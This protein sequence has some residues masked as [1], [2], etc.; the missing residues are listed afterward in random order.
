MYRMANLD[1]CCILWFSIFL[2]DLVSLN[3]IVENKIKD[4]N[5]EFNDEVNPH[6]VTL[7][8]EIDNQQNILTQL[9]GDY[10]KVKALSEGSDCGCKCVVR[11]LSRSACRRIHEGSAEPQD[12]YTVETVTSGSDCKCTCI[13][14]PSA[15]NPCE[16]DFRL[17]KLQDAGKDNIKLSTIMELLEGAFYGM[18]L[19]KLHSV[20]TKLINR[21][22][23]IEKA[24]SEKSQE[25]RVFVKSSTHRPA[26]GKESHKEADKKKPV[27]QAVPPLKGNTTAGSGNREG[28]YEERL[29]GNQGF[30]RPLLKR[31]QPEFHKGTKDDQEEQRSPPQSKAA[32]QDVVIRGVTYYKSD[33]GDNV[34]REDQAVV[35]EVV[36]GDGSVDLL[37]EDQ[38][39]KEGR[40]LSKVNK[41]SKKAVGRA[42]QVAR[43]TLTTQKHNITVAEMEL[44]T[45][46]PATAKQIIKQMTKTMDPVMVTTPS[47][48]TT[49]ASTI[50]S[51]TAARITSAILNT[52][53]RIDV[54]NISSPSNTSGQAEKPK[55]RI[56]W[57]ES[58][59]DQKMAA[60]S[61]KNPGICKDTLATIGDPVTHNTFGHSEG[62]WMKDP[63]G[64]DG[65]IYVTNYYHGNNLLEFSNIEAF[66]E[67]RPTNSYKLPYNWMGTGHVVYRKAFYYNRAF[68]R[69]IIKFDLNR[70]YV[71]AWTVLDDAVVDEDNH[72]TGRSDIDFAVDESGLWVIYPAMDD[73][74]FHQE[75][76]VLSKLNPADLSMQ[77]ETSWRT[78]LR[79]NFYGNCF[80]VCGVLYA[81]DS[82]DQMNANISYAF[83]T[84]TNT[85][86]IPRLPFLN[87]Y[88][89]NMQV[90]YNPKERALYSWD[91]GHQV[92]Y[93]V[94][95]A[96]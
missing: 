73:E 14:P 72:W 1:L 37:I 47:P 12:F 45:T 44:T 28:K 31:S 83:D 2:C 30:S 9:L 93:S 77:K 38:L 75:V 24:V 94:I 62:A 32:S 81:I 89:Y 39:L 65:R 10:D 20:T 78:A 59:A 95:F 91:N 49:V 36:S 70:R 80:V 23:N 92:T 71:A 67:G 85:Q 17:K 57:T 66:K 88:T 33:T 52:T 58:P 56:S 4:T 82:F 54:S 48:Q 42:A 84:H 53:T 7:V 69:D 35:D 46:I 74:G 63:K 6:N 41:K 16:G 50:T 96:Y 90:D 29:L 18:D 43:T 15:L 79:R 86:M 61:Q 27:S 13:A 68:S 21:I 8:E 76:I 40:G 11:P 19:L 55:S 25:E 26:Q 87:S 60:E 3:E 34:D 5:F 22:E 51:S 64:N